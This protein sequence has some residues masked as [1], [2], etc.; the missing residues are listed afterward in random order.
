MCNKETLEVI[1][2]RISERAK[3]EF[4][5]QLSSVILYG[6]YAREDYDDESDIDVMIIVDLPA[7]RMKEFNRVF[8]DFS[9]E[10]D[11]QYDVVVSLLLQD[12]AT[13]ERWK[14]SSLF[15]KNVLK[16]GVEFVA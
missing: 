3:K 10:L 15:F 7:G 11:L 8:S 12:K 4:G 9:L 14:E 1:L 6:S 13:F 2:E 5:A 16:E